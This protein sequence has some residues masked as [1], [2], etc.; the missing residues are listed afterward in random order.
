MNRFGNCFNTL[1]NTS[2]L[3]MLTISALFG[4]LRIVPLKILNTSTI[5]NIS[6]SLRMIKNMTSI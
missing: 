4:T 5:N 1:L 6:I 3:L 2:M